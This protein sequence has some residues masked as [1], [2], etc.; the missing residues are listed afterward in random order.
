MTFLS[1]SWETIKWSNTLASDAEHN[2]KPLWQLFGNGFMAGWAFTSF[3]WISVLGKIDMVGGISLV[4]LGVAFI[5]LFWLEVGLTS[6]RARN[7]ILGQ[8]KALMMMNDG[9]VYFVTKMAMDNASMYGMDLEIRKSDAAFEGLD[10]FTIK[11]Y[12]GLYEGD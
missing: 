7:Y 3:L 4:L 2:C 1:K 5:W 6:Y 11:R 10:N 9:S 12:E 8:V